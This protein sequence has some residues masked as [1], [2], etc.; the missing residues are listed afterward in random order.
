MAMEAKKTSNGVKH[1]SSSSPI[2][3]LEESQ[4]H[5][6]SG[7]STAAQNQLPPFSHPR[8]APSSLHLY[9]CGGLGGI[10]LWLNRKKHI[11]NMYVGCIA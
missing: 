10:Y 1:A 2:F 6:L 3:S 8:L 5:P 9:P 4:S 11:N 7:V